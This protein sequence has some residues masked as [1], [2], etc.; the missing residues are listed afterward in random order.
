MTG[1]DDATGRLVAS[2]SGGDRAAIVALLERYAGDV[3]RYVARHARDLLGQHES[4][5][6]VAQSVCR[7]V[8]ERLADARLSYLG[9]PQFRQWLYNAVRF[10]LQNRHREPK[11]QPLA[12]DGSLPGTAAQTALFHDLWTPSRQAVLH[13]EFARFQA[14]FAQLSA[15]DQQIITLSRLD[16]RSHKDIAALLG[17]TEVSSRA[18]LSRAL[19]RLANKASQP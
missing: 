11:A 3:E 13:E 1:G 5:A 10:R 8:L 19:V 2:A 18:L 6:D 16:G 12:S 15:K 14:A 9:E 17:I 7:E 4:A